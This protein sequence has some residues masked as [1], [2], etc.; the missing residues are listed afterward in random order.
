MPRGWPEAVSP[1]GTRGWEETAEGWLLGLMPGYRQNPAAREH[2]VVLAFIARHVLDGAVEG[3]R[4]GYRVT[5]REL[6][7]QVPP[8]VVAA[9]L[10]EFRAEGRRLSE[11]L[12][13]VELVEGALR[14][15]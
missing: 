2:P 6:A 7:G 3:A 8:P 12:R 9:A 14:R 5:R 15:D 11:V 4:Q 13:A 1:P 10:A